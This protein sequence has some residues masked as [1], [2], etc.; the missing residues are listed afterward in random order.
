MERDDFREALLGI[1]E[2]KQHW[3]WSSFSNG[4]VPADRLHIHLENNILFPRALQL[5]AQLK[6][7]E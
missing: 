5:E 7:P 1:M 4:L 6:G 3:A 2:R